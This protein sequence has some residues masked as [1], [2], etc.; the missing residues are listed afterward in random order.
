[1]NSEYIRNG[2]VARNRIAMD[3]KYRKLKRPEIEQ[4][5]ADPMIADSIIGNSYSEKKPMKEWNKTY[6]DELSYTAIAESFNRDYLLY[7]D[8]VAD[9]ISKATFKR[10]VVAGVII[11]L[12]IIAGVIVFQYELKK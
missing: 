10:N 1:M 11:V 5:L 8:E 3:I 9:Y 6:L 12:V 4:L 2:R 7:L